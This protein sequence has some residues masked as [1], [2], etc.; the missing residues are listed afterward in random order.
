MWGR[1]IQTDLV[2]WP[3][4]LGGYSLHIMCKN[5]EGIVMQ[6]FAALRAAVFFTI[7]EKPPGGGY[8]PPPLVGARVK[9]I[10]KSSL[11]TAKMLIAHVLKW[12]LIEYY[13]QNLLTN[14]LLSSYSIWS[15]TVRSLFSQSPLWSMKV[16]E[17]LMVLKTYKIMA[18]DRIISA[19]SQYFI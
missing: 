7:Y 1:V 5:D 18:F 4:K 14:Y 13:L 16:R 9:H 17:Y 6:N 12:K 8:P 19:T 11:F 10:C 15:F 3:L 2:T